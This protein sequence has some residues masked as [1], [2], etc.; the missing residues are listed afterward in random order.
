LVC[1]SSADEQL[2][3]KAQAYLDVLHQ[4]E[5]PTSAPDEGAKHP[6]R[7]ARDKDIK[8]E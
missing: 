7:D 6:E 1:E 8:Q 4:T 3:S 2:R 5:R